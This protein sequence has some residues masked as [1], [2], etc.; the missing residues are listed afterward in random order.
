MNI[1]RKE[2]E[3]QLKPGLHFRSRHFCGTIG[4]VHV[5]RCHRPGFQ[6]EEGIVLQG[7][8]LVPRRK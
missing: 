5:P 3:H 8:V 7:P 2:E 6:G 1:L 4:S